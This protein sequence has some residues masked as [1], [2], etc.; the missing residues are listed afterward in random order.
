MEPVRLKTK[1]T[2]YMLCTLVDLVASLGDWVTILKPLYM[3]TGIEQLRKRMADDRTQVFH[4]WSG[5][6][7]A[8]VEG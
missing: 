5:K 8:R 7:R 1:G 4:C 2:V 6:L 3:N